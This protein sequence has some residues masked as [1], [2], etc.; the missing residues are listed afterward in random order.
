MLPRKTWFAWDE[1]HWASDDSGEVYRQ[2]K[3]TVATIYADA[4]A[5]LDTDRRKALAKWA[6]ASESDARINAM[7]SLARSEPGIPVAP[8]QLD[9][10]PWLF[11]VLNGTIELRT[12][13][14]REQRRDDMIT[15]LAPVTYEPNARDAVFE[16]FLDR[17]L[18]DS[19]QGFVQRA[20][21][22]SLTC[23]DHTHISTLSRLAKLLWQ[24][25]S[26]SLVLDGSFTVEDRGDIP[27][28]W[29]QGAINVCTAQR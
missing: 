23:Y 13:E 6:A 26:S 11:N 21:G 2:A 27:G 12:G 8:Q 4:A 17:V 29:A 3:A 22:Y 28:I 9:T 24:A 20:A 10:D 18:P 5:E 15:M 1:T 25:R 19:L 16:N 7:I 14:L